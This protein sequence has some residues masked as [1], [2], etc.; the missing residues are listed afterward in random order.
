MRTSSKYNFQIL[1]EPLF[2]YREI[3][4]DYYKKYFKGFVSVLYLMKKYNYNMECLLFGIKYISTG[5]VYYLY[6]I[7]GKENVLVSNRNELKF[8]SQSVEEV[9]NKI[10]E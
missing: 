2:F 9:L 10:H 8:R 5:L 1:N 6:G 4:T 3:G 7:I